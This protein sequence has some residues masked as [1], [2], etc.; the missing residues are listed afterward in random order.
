MLQE[1]LKAFESELGVLGRGGRTWVHIDLSPD[2]V[3]V[4]DTAPL[5]TQIKFLLAMNSVMGSARA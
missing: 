2:Q 1:L 5:H 3:R 4:I